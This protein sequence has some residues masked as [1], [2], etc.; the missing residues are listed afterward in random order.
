MEC[1]LMGHWD[2]WTYQEWE[3]SKWNRTPFYCGPEAN[4]DRH[5]RAL[6]L[7]SHLMWNCI[8][9]EM[10]CVFV[11]GEIKSDLRG[12][13]AL[14]LHPA[15]PFI[16]PS[17]L[18]SLS[19]SPHTESKSFSIYHRLSRM[20]PLAVTAL[21]T[22]TGPSPP[23]PLPIPRLSW[24]WQPPRGRG[25]SSRCSTTSNGCTVPVFAGPCSRRRDKDGGGRG[26]W[27]WMIGSDKTWM[28]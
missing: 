27:K 2:G 24:H 16:A 4:T 22:A 19:S 21:A 1:L 12:R 15:S 25:R 8:S 9:R 5:M 28:S 18:N 13:P 17:I 3:T 10:T 14:Q 20:T 7:T 26:V 6:F 23:L 11:V